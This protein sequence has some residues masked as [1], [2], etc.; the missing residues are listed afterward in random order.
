MLDPVTAVIVLTMVLPAIIGKCTDVATNQGMDAWKKQSAVGNALNE[1]VKTYNSKTLEEGLK[2]WV[3]SD[4][5]TTSDIAKGK[6]W[7]TADV[8][9]SFSNVTSIK[10]SPIAST[11]LDELLCEFLIELAVQLEL[12]EPAMR[13][14]SD[15]A[16]FLK[17]M[18]RFDDQ[19]KQADMRH[20]QILAKFDELT[21]AKVFSYEVT[22][23]LTR[24]PAEIEPHSKIDTAMEHFKRGRVNKAK[25][26]LLALRTSLGTTELS[27]ELK[28]RLANAL[29]ASYS[30]LEHLQ[31]AHDEFQYA[32]NYKRSRSN[33]SNLA[34]A[35]LNLGDLSG[36]LELSKKAFAVQPSNAF[37]IAI[38]VQALRLNG[39]HDEAQ[40]IQNEHADLF[41]ADANCLLALGQLAYDKG[42]YLGAKDHFEKAH[43]KAPY[44]AQMK[45]LI[46]NCILKDIEN[47][48]Q[49]VTPL[50]GAL[51]TAAKDGLT[52]VMELVAEALDELKD[53]DY[54]I[55]RI[56]AY[57]FQAAGRFLERDYENAEK[58]CREILN[59]DSD[60]QLAL[61][62]MGFIAHSVRKDNKEAIGYFEQVKPELLA[63]MA[64][65]AASAYIDEKEIK[66]AKACLAAFKQ[67][68]QRKKLWYCYAHEQIRVAAYDGTQ[69]AAVEELL[70]EYHDNGDVLYA[71]GEYYKEQKNTGKALEYFALAKDSNNCTLKLFIPRMQAQTYFDAQLWEPAYKIYSSMPDIDKY[72]KDWY[73]YI[74]TMANMP[75]QELLGSAGSQARQARERNGGALIPIISEIE[76][77]AKME[78]FCNPRE[79]LRLLIPIYNDLEHSPQTLYLIQIA[80]LRCGRNANNLDIPN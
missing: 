61:L 58:A 26:E 7:A 69:E 38:H 63:P 70:S 77:L 4:E 23:Q 5:F 24:L 42:D 11:E 59:L 46:A 72:Q 62:K 50:D 10:S 1:F 51:S 78:K 48:F 18:A 37:T 71:I 32:L 34:A 56:R 6:A 79:A 15:R 33:L 47:P 27:D 57:E 20:K 65:V 2:K 31:P 54:P 28:S 19:D 73:E 17:I 9:A 49:E 40:K 68:A 80:N 75:N 66:K 64:V 76:A 74:C 53:N 13:V 52:K 8:V 30:K 14:R 41:E 43:S 39:L 16:R 67:E 25:D 45:L 12:A 36:G 21:P 3:T 22:E 35:K 29:G 60:N 44:D 55:N